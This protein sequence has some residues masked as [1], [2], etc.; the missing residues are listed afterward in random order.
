M[1]LTASRDK[2]I[3]NIALSA[4]FANIFC[5]EPPRRRVGWT[6]GGVVAKKNTEAPE[7]R[8]SCCY[9]NI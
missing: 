1:Y 5:D 4:T 6:F 2:Y 9:E 8:T 3:N 7:N